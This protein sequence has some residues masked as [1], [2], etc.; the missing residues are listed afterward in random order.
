MIQIQA[1]CLIYIQLHVDTSYLLQPALG[2]V[3]ALVPLG[4]VLVHLV[5][6]LAGRLLSG[7]GYP[8]VAQGAVRTSVRIRRA[9]ELLDSRFDGTHAFRPPATRVGSLPASCAS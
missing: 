4:H 5:Q 8:G 3:A 7:V 6:L 2:P 9:F 1:Q